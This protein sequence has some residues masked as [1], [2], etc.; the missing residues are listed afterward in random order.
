MKRALRSISAW[1]PHTH[2]AL[3]AALM[4]RLGISLPVSPINYSPKY[5][6]QGKETPRM[7]QQDRAALSTEE[8]PD[9]E[10]GWWGW[11]G[12]GGG[13]ALLSLYFSSSQPAGAFN[14]QLM[15]SKVAL[16]MSPH[17]LSHSRANRC[18]KVSARAAARGTREKPLAA[19]G[20]PPCVIAV[21]GRKSTDALTRN[22][23][24]PDCLFTLLISERNH[25]H[26]SHPIIS[27]NEH[28]LVMQSRG[29]HGY[30]S[31]NSSAAP[32]C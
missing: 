2:K 17:F 4:P 28:F 18:S 27:T 25:K 16:T 12:R 7:G 29:F 31:A 15:Y 20:S 32:Q 11:R 13:R 14:L 9:K 30:Q 19:S 10:S 6:S 26:S 5:R 8:R 3:K 22:I 24:L 1:K 23:E 21:V